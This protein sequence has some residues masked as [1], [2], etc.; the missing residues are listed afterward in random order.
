MD[1]GLLCSNAH[2]PAKTKLQF[3]LCKQI[4][5]YRY[6]GHI[7]VNGSF[8]FQLKVLG[9]Y[10]R[11]ES[12]TVDEVRILLKACHNL[13]SLSILLVPVDHFKCDHY[14]LHQSQSDP[15]PLTLPNL[16]TFT[17]IA[18]HVEKKD[19]YYIIKYLQGLSCFSSG[20]WFQVNILLKCK[21][22]NIRNNL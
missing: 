1:H 10:L 16:K 21:L 14:W 22:V 7:D 18:F 5:Y 20:Q 6:L 8:W 2:T 3:Q 17:V 9:I 15:Q 12:K 13:H 19:V 11:L 4:H